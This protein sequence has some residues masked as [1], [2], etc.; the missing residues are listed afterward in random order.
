MSEPPG[1][2]SAQGG[3]TG[4]SSWYTGGRE[5][6]V[7]Q[8][9][10]NAKLLQYSAGMAQVAWNRF[11]NN[12][13]LERGMSLATI[14]SLKGTGLLLKIV[15]EPMFSVLAD[16]TEPKLVYAV[17]MIFGTLTLEILRLT[18]PLTF[19]VV[20]WVKILRITVAPATTLV[21]TAS[22]HLIRGSS[23]GFGEQRAFGSLAWG[24]GAFITG[25]AIDKFGIDAIFFITYFFHSICL[26]VVMLVLPR[27]TNTA[28]SN[29]KGS[30]STATANKAHQSPA[31]KSTVV[32][33]LD[34]ND[35]EMSLLTKKDSG[36]DLAHEGEHA[37]LREL[38][39]SSRT[40]S[41]PASSRLSSVD[42]DATSFVFCPARCA[43]G[44]SQHSPGGGCLAECTRYA[45]MYGGFMATGAV[46]TLL[47][48]VLAY[49]VIMQVHETF[50]YLLVERDFHATRTFS[51]LLTTVS[52]LCCLPVFWYVT[53]TLTLIVT[54]TVTPTL[55]LTLTPTLLS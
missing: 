44:E 43:S 53:P 11:Q 39:S 15:G 35:E 25:L 30:V 1:D 19:V 51:G 41:P 48:N 7:R 4:F 31:H 34:T 5:I 13:Y 8:K 18:N 14:G 49:G 27:G 38:Q 10:I 26:V 22:L 40:P 50:L 54:V 32:T 36:V 45:E 23:E 21:T 29:T 28:W 6:S 9:L 46:R 20:L 16:V 24:T 17:C 42:S 3:D 55:T 52:V 33:T 12:F 2:N 37:H 47:F